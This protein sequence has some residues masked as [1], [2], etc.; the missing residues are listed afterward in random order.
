MKGKKAGLGLKETHDGVSNTESFN[1]VKRASNRGTEPRLPWPIEMLSPYSLRPAQRNVR[2]HAKRQIQQIADSMTRFGVINPVVVDERGRII[3]GHARVE[4]AK[5]LGIGRIP[6]IRI[7]H[8][9]EVEIRA[10]MLADNKL[11]EKAGWDREMLAVELEELQIALP[12]IGLD[13][14]ITG[15]EPGEIDSIMHDFGEGPSNPADQLPD[16]ETEARAARVGDLFVLGRHRILVGDARDPKAYARLM[17]TQT[18]DMAFLDPPYNVRVDGHTGGRGRIKHREFACASG[19]MTSDQYVVFLQETLGQCVRHTIDG[20]ITYVCTDWR[21]AREL[22]EAG[23]TVFDELKNICVWAKTTPG[24]GTFYRSQHEL[25]FVYKRGQAPH[26]NT[27]ELGQH[28][29][30]RSN[31]WTYAGANTFRAGRMDELR[32]H[33]TIKPVA[34]IADAMRDCSRRGSIILDAFAGSGSTIMAAEQVGRRGFCMEIDPGYVDVTIRRWQRFTGRDAILEATAQTFDEL[35]ATGA[36]KLNPPKDLKPHRRQ[37]M[38]KD[39]DAQ[40]SSRA[41][42]Q[43]L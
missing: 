21:H 10:Y 28:G 26:L 4:A 17:Q 32:M 16:I 12:E 39:C 19:E 1:S 40:E 8:L 35:F 11:P 42:I 34:L 7:S 9:N 43:D 2:R 41:A 14:G 33:P 15:F 20:G 29:R 6:V 31:V 30:S 37:M 22:L 13:V 5:L 18:A 24:Q 27:F 23:G 3:A 38:K 25:V 36:R